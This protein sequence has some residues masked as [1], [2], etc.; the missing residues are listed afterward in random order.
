MKCSALVLLLCLAF[1]SVSFAQQNPADAPA[2]TEDI[3]QYLKV[4]HSSDTARNTLDAMTKPFHQMIHEQLAKIPNL[5]P[6][7]EAREFKMFDEII[8]SFPI[9][10]MQQ[11]MVPV[12]EKHLTKGDVK[13]LTAFYSTPTGQKILKEMPAISAEAMQ[14]V[15]P[16]M[17]KMMAKAMESVQEQIAQIQKQSEAN[18]KKQS[19]PTAN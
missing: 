11:A 10:E 19:P 4:V 14:A 3:E 15:M 8:K 13:A 2:S 16:I 12:Y 9:D 1:A 18:S 5:P 17:Q 6:D 7:A